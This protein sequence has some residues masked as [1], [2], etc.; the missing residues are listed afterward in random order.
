M[1]NFDRKPSGEPILTSGDVS[2]DLL[3]ALD[4]AAAAAPGRETRAGLMS[5]ILSEW[6]HAKGYLRHTG[7]D[8]GVRPE[9]L[10]SEND[11]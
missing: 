11:S 1:T 5:R 4:R 6:L 10:T 3:A 9:N 8:E 7:C 2:P